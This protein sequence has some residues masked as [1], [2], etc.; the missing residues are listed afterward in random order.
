[1]LAEVKSAISKVLTAQEYDAGAGMSVRRALL[2]D[3]NE[4]EKWLLSELAKFGELGA[5]FNPIN[6]VEFGEPL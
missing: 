1:M 6:L 2:K 5:G 3:L 4:R